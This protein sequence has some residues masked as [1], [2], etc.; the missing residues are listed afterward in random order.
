MGKLDHSAEAEDS[1]IMSVIGEVQR[2]N[3]EAYAVLITKFQRQIFLYCYYLLKDIEEAED[4]TQDIFIKGLVRI[5]Q[6]VNTGSFSAW[7]YKI[8]YHHCIDLIKKMNK[9]R[10]SLFEYRLK[11]EQEKQNEYTDIIHEYLDRLNLEERQILL[12]RSLEEYTY[13][14][15][16]SI[17]GLKSST[18]RKKYERL[19]KKLNKVKKK[20]VDLVEHSF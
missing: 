15:I 5:E 20:G 16:A 7:L 9:G 6:Y 19:R 8:A 10:I 17:M 18:V 3:K 12:L 1:A 13:D 11:K 14:E 2:G 4:A